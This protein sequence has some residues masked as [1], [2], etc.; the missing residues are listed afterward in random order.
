MEIK[1]TGMIDAT[2]TGMIDPA[3]Q[4]TPQT[5]QNNDGLFS[6]V[7]RA[8]LSSLAPQLHRLLDAIGS[9]NDGMQEGLRKN[10]ESLQDAFMDA[11][12]T[13]V[14]ESSGSA[15]NK[16][17]LGI[18]TSG[19]LSVTNDHPDKDTI[20]ALLAEHPALSSAF[21]EIAAQSE[22]LHNMSKINVAALAS[23]GSAA[24]ESMRLGN[25]V[26]SLEY[27]LSVKGDMNHFYFA[28]PES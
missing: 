14:L 6:V 10:I 22:L 15:L 18:D 4:K 23:S 28:L 7:D 19:L 11:L 9:E 3:R 17:T 27:R 24:Y 2:S 13:E 26:Q 5:A 8:G 20:N 1:E 16:V 21:K 25:A 12:Y